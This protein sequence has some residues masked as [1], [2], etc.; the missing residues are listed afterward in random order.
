MKIKIR[1]IIT[2]IFLSIFSYYLYEVMY[3]RSHTLATVNKFLKNKMIEKKD[4]SKKQLNILIKVQD[5]NFYFHNGVDL[6]TPGAGWTTITQSLAKQ[7]Y[8]KKFNQGIKKIKQTLCARYA[9]HPLVS[10]D[11]QI[12]LFLNMMYFGNNQYGIVNA[13]KFYYSKKVNDLS[14]D[15]YISLIACLILPSNLNVKDNPTENNIR[16]KR[17]KKMLS[18]KYTPNGVF[19]IL[20][21]KN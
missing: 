8:F 14:E 10:K 20:Y 12:T 5:P 2:V 19:D 1:Y 11:L 4:L 16:L 17:I 18:G 7:F 9:L 21:D 13:A 6:S 3:A 15:E